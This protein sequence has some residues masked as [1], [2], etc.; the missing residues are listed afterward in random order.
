MAEEHSGDQISTKGAREMTIS[1]AVRLVNT[2]IEAARKR[3]KDIYQAKEA[4]PILA[5]G[6]TSTGY[7]A[8]VMA[9]PSGIAEIM[10]RYFRFVFIITYGHLFATLLL[11]EGVDIRYI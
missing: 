1:E 4:T 7:C 8:K 5:E 2:K 9:N 3:L 10:L 6:E 11:K